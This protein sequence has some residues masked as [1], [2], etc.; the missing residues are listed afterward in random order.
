V[1]EYDLIAVEDLNIQGLARTP[2]GN[3]SILDAA[4]VI[5]YH[6]SGSSGGKTRRSCGEN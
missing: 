5:F 4:G 2:W 1:R 6:R 3:K